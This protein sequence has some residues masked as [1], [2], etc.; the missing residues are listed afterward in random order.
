MDNSGAQYETQVSIEVVLDKG[1]ELGVLRKS[2][3][4]NYW[5]HPAIHLH[6]QP[7]FEKSYPTPEQRAVAGRAYA[8]AQGWFGI[9]FTRVLQKGARAR[10]VEALTKDADNFEQGLFAGHVN[11]WKQAEIG[12]L[13]G[14][15][16]LL[17][18][19]GRFEQWRVLFW[20]VWE[21][22]IGP[23][24]E[25]L[26]GCELWWSFVMDHRLRIA[27]EDQ[28]VETGEPIALLVKAH[29]ERQT[30]GIPRKPGF[31]YNEA[32][33]RALNDLAIATG[34]LAD[35]LRQ[36]EDAK[37]VALNEEAI[38]LYELIGEKTAI[39]IR[40]LNLGHCYKNVPSIRDLE[41]AEKH[42]RLA[43]DNY[44]EN[45]ALARSQAV[46][47]ISMT[48]LDAIRERGEDKPL[49]QKLKEKLAETIEQ[50]EKPSRDCLPML[51]ATLRTCTTTLPMRC[52][53][54][55]TGE[56]K[57]MITSGWPTNTPLQ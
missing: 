37:C 19:Q 9:Q 30:A 38:A 18:H 31:R 56:T 54:I 45:D 44:P 12:I 16:A 1:V 36:K 17:V 48:W 51:G 35:V 8:E 41:A 52:V 39:A 55:Q 43:I 25:P 10:V 34:R 5:L 21:D 7:F 22:F 4:H 23:D 53:S 50:Y 49:P 32:Q 13:H 28:D 11:G 42:Y 40:E 47:Q 24:M 46:A 26:P 3:D 2:E 20:E 27:L 15:N 33:R 6:L 57:R 29:E 14:L